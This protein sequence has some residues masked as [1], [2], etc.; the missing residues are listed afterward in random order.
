MQIKL[1][2]CAL[3]ALTTATPVILQGIAL[4]ATALLTSEPSMPALDDVRHF[5]DILITSQRSVLNV[6]WDV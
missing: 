4:V 5:M 6:L 3:A 2:L 1:S